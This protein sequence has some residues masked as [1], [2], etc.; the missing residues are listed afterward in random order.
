MKSFSLAD[1]KKELQLLPAG[2][3]A[4]LCISL[5]KFKKENKDFLGYLL[6]DSYDKPGFVADIKKEIDAE[7]SSLRSQPNLYYVKKSLR[8]LLR[9]I[10]RY[11]KYVNDKSVTCDLH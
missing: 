6:V 4:D 1:L 2:D 7:F 3:L 11:A 5:A 10:N 9:I 8:K